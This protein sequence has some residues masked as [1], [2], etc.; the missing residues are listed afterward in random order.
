[1]LAAGCNDSFSPPEPPAVE[2]GVPTPQENA[3]PL[4]DLA[5]WADGY[6]LANY[7]TAA[8]HSPS[9]LIS[10]NRSGGRVTITKVAGTTG[11]Y[12]ARFG[13]LSGLLGGKSTVHVT[14][15][16]ADATYCK[17]VGASLVRDSVE[18]RC[19]KIGTGAAVNARFYLQVTGKHD[20]RA[21]A[22]AHQPT[23]T[24][25]APT[26][27]GSW[28]PAGASRVFREGV[29]R[30]RV[31]FTGF[32]GRLSANGGHVQVN[33]AGT[34]KGHCK[35]QYWNDGQDLN[36]YVRCSTPAGAPADAKFTVLVTPPAAHLAYVWGDQPTSDNYTPDSFYSS[37]PVGGAITI[38]RSAVGEYTVRWTGV[39]AEIRDLGNVQVTAYGDDG[40]QCKVGGYV[41]L[42]SA[43]V[44]CFAANGVAVDAYFTV[45][46]HS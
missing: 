27:P 39:D 6:L 16:G 42:D 43:P 44:R 30:Y 2:N 23:A 40:A 26:S 34:G 24:N 25:Y 14:G 13:G 32:G 15:Y 3:G 22:S 37:N 29:G 9:S 5:Y 41:Q 38:T 7:P 35:V 28:N 45:M 17:P 11:R 19:F 33:A 12:V 10:F 31:V 21:F 20:D 36:V 4:E 18:V 46:F 8:A 1:L